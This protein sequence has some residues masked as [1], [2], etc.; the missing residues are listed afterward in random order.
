MR[1]NQDESVGKK[2]SSMCKSNGRMSKGWK[3]DAEDIVGVE[4][5]GLRG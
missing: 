3:D 1:Q 4:D 2:R 5:A